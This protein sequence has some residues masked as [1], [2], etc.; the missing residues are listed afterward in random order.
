MENEARQKKQLLLGKSCDL[1]TLV[2]DAA[3]GCLQSAIEKII[4]THYDGDVHYMTQFL[5]AVGLSKTADHLVNIPVDA[6][7]KRILK[8]LQ[9]GV[10]LE[11][12]GDAIP[13]DY[14]TEWLKSRT[15]SEYGPEYF[16][17][18]DEV[19]PKEEA[20]LNTAKEELLKVMDSAQAEKVLSLLPKFWGG[21]LSPN[22]L[23]TGS[24]EEL[25]KNVFDNASSRTRIE[26][27]KEIDTFIK[28]IPGFSRN[29]MPELSQ[30]LNAFL[31]ESREALREEF[32]ES[33]PRTSG[34]I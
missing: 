31:A 7:Q 26:R 3:S 16:R 1:N 29:E 20:L 11:Q 4:R 18:A 5:Y 12:F 10:V 6:I 8:E 19:K 2:N 24:K 14:A 30:K 28:D 32:A 9:P 15:P 21:I 27:F 25:L 33:H 34:C 22:D 13:D 23:K 17:L